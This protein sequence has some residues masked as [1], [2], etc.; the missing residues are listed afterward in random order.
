MFPPG[1]VM[2]AVHRALVLHQERFPLRLR[3]RLQDPLR[4]ERIFA[5]R[6]VDW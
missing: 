5:R 2:R 6:R 4:V 3:Q 1:R